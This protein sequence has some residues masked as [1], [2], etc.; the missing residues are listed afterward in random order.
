MDSDVLIWDQLSYSPKKGKASVTEDP[1]VSK[2]R[3]VKGGASVYLEKDLEKA[4]G[5]Q[6]VLSLDY[7]LDNIEKPLADA[8]R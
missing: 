8:T 2:L 6:T 3:A 5:W 7:L 1:I 4:F